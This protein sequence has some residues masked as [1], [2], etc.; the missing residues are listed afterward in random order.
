M[1]PI[2]TG[3]SRW[4]RGN[5]Q[6]RSPPLLR[7]GSENNSARCMQ[8]MWGATLPFWMWYNSISVWGCFCWNWRTGPTS[9]LPTSAEGREEW[10]PTPASR[11][12]SVVHSYMESLCADIARNNLDH[13]PDLTVCNLHMGC[14]PPQVDGT[15]QFTDVQKGALGVC[16]AF[17][18]KEVFETTMTR[19]RRATLPFWI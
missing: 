9:S 19:S 6:W 4:I 15:V 13:P 1:L 17:S 2:S 5:R 14:L 8:R 3:R 7:E 12:V 11:T 16:A 18:P 10:C